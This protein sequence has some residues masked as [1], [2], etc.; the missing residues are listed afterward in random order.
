MRIRARILLVDDNEVD[1]VFTRRMLSRLSTGD[2]MSSH[3]MVE[4]SPGVDEALVALESERHDVCLVD[5]QLGDRNGLD[6]LR[7][8]RRRGMRVPMI[9][10]TGRGDPDVDAQAMALGA[11]GYLDKETIDPEQLDRALRYALTRETLIQDLLEQNEELLHQHRLTELALGT[12]PLPERLTGMLQQISRASG[13][14]GVLISRYERS[15]ESLQP[16]AGLTFSGEALSP[17]TARSLDSS[18]AGGVLRARRARIEMDLEGNLDQEILTN[19]PSARSYVCLPLNNQDVALGVLELASPKAQ[20]IDSR[21]LDH[22]DSLA[23]HLAMLL[24]HLQ[25]QASLMID[26]PRTAKSEAQTTAK[27]PGSQPIG[28]GEPKDGDL[29]TLL[30]WYGHRAERNGMQLQHE[31]FRGASAPPGGDALRLR[32]LISAY[33]SHALRFGGPGQVLVTTRPATGSQ[34]D[35]DELQ[36]SFQLPAFGESMLEWEPCLDAGRELV[37]SL[38]GQLEATAVPGGGLRI[39]MSASLATTGA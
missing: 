7:E 30:I 33:V 26:A 1:F 25:G 15:Q 3:Y 6:L 4:W 24:G 21:Q 12:D 29:D 17:D 28:D 18:V 23:S 20:V 13:F 9:L 8:A 22:L 27:P 36:V 31:L 5:Y 11:A 19:W 37:R 10:L 38:D 35:W 39:R 16:M 14:A 32:R 2:P 34:G